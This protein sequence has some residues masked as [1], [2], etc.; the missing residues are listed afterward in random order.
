MVTDVLV[1]GGGTVGAA[2]A[3]GLAQR[4]QKVTVLDG[5]DRDYRAARA[6]FGL[7]WVQGKGANMPEYQLLSQRSAELWGGFS[8]SL[9]HDSGTELQL[10]QRGGFVFSLS[11]AEF[12]ARR[13]TLQKMH[14]QLGGNVDWEM[15]D[16]SQLERM[17]PAVRFGPDV[18]GASYG[19]RDGHVNPLFLLSALHAGIER[20]GGKIVSSTHAHAIRADGA[21]FAVETAAE[22]YRASR[23]VIAAGLGSQALGAQVGLEVPLRPQRGQ[24]LVTERLNPVFP[25]PASGLRQTREGTIMIGATNED[26]GFDV[27]TTGAGAAKLSSRALRIVPALANVNLVRQWAGLRVLSPDNC[28]IYA[29]SETHPGAFIAACH[30]GIT[31]AAVHAETVAQA[32]LAG[33]LPQSLEVFHQR[34]FNVSEAA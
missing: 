22:T 14:N 5:G 4:H 26:V 29:Q 23:I 7:L 17:V 16:R 1:I 33:A 18:C 30:S 13:I 31:L 20:L 15:V 19:H 3:Y 8:A 34:R 12:E 9:Q 25:F 10:E 11:E 21:G 27:T 24:I 32:V 28:P 6:N 2:I